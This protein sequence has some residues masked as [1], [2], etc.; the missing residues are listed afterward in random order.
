MRPHISILFYRVE[1]QQMGTAQIC[2]QDASCAP[3]K[4]PKPST[5]CFMPGVVGKRKT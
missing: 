1:F 5:A 3:R 2:P 4:T